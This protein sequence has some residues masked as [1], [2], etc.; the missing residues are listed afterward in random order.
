VQVVDTQMQKDGN[1]IGLNGAFL[2]Y[3]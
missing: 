1:I 3:N 2:R